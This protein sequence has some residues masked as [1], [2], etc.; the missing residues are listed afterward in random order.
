MTDRLDQIYNFIDK[1][2]KAVVVAALFLIFGTGW[3]LYEKRD[4]IIE[5]WLTPSAPYL[6]TTR[7]TQA[8]DVLATET[9]ADLLQI[10]EIDLPR[11]TQQFYAARRKDGER[12]VI[13]IPRRLPVI[14]TVSSA[15]ALV[16]ILEG[17]PV[18]VDLTEQGTPLAERLAQRG[19]KRGCAIPI[20][21]SSDAF[22][23]VIYLAWLNPP[24]DRSQTVAVGAARDV[25]RT[26]VTQ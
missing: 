21:P 14:T 10:W 5:S 2:W 16:D 6:K 1:P 18:C 4:A 8:L 15:K 11:N 3:V 22:V 9:S 26:L 20:P 19:M 23:G 24:D 13:P 7:I 25:A 17:R 12:P